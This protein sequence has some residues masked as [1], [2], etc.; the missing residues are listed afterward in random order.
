MVLTATSFLIPETLKLTSHQAL[1]V[2]HATNYTTHLPI[3]PNLPFLSPVL[4]LSPPSAFHIPASMPSPKWEYLNCQWT[5][6]PQT[7]FTPVP[8]LWTILLQ[9]STTLLASLSKRLYW[10]SIDGSAFKKVTLSPSSRNSQITPYLLT[11]WR[12]APS[13]P[14]PPFI[15][16]NPLVSLQYPS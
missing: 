1:P 7:Y 16:Q 8:K 10:C 2:A 9:Y 4:A 15:R 6:L 12:P 14:N 11:S 3:T 5:P 13:S